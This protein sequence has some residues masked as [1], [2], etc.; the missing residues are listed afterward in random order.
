MCC[1]IALKLFGTSDKVERANLRAQVVPL[2]SSVQGVQAAACRQQGQLKPGSSVLRPCTAPRE[3]SSAQARLR[4]GSGPLTP[5]PLK[6]A[7]AHL[8]R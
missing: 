6:A 4:H 7:A 2:G 1:P 8:R 5:A 3:L